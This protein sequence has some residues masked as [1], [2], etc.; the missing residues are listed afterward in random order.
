MASAGADLHE[1]SP[2]A[3]GLAVTRSRPTFDAFGK[4]VSPSTGN[5]VMGPGHVGG[6][7]DGF[8]MAFAPDIFGIAPGT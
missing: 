7:G 2:H 4:V 1:H 8:R 5:Y 3:S 6:Y